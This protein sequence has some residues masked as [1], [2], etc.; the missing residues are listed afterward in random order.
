MIRHGS[1]PVRISQL[2]NHCCELI[3]PDL[4]PIANHGIDF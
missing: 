4:R 3:D 2:D 1:A